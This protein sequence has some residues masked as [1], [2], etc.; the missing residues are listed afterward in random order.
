MTS[1]NFNNIKELGIFIFLGLFILYCCINFSIAIFFFHSWL[2]NPLSCW[3]FFGLSLVILPYASFFISM[4][5]K[6]GKELTD[7]SDKAEIHK[8]SI[9]LKAGVAGFL[10]W[11][12]VLVV[13]EKIQIDIN[14]PLSLLCGFFLFLGIFWLLKKINRRS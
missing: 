12:I 10:I 1:E 2:K 3:I 6:S 8:R 11:L 13:L 14:N 9:S 5:L 7:E 4:Y